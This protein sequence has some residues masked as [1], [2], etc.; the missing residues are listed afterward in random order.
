MICTHCKGLIIKEKGLIVTESGRYH[1]GCDRNAPEGIYELRK[2][3]DHEFELE[4]RL[5]ERSKLPSMTSDDV[6]DIW[7]S[8]K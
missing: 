7:E 4:E 2:Q 1:R 6:L 8:L 3:L 5:M